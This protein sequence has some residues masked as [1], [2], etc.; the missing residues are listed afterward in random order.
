M[1]RRKVLKQLALAIPGSMILPGVLSSCVDDDDGPEFIFGGKVIVIGAG[2]A[3]LYAA[4]YLLN[5]KVNVQVLEAS[6]FAGG[7]V[8]SISGF[9]DFPLEMGASEIWGTNNLLHEELIAASIP[10]LDQKPLG[11]GRYFID[12]AISTLEEIQ[13]DGDFNT[14]VNFIQGIP[15]YSGPAGSIRTAAENAGIDPRVMNFLQGKVGQRY[16][17]NIQQLSMPAIAN[18][19]NASES[20]ED[21]RVMSG[22]S[23]RNFLLGRYSRA[24][25]N[26]KFNTAVTQIDYSDDK[27]VLTDSTGETYTADK[28]ILTVPISMIKNGAINFSPGLPNAKIQALSRMEMSACLRI[29]VRFNNNFWGHDVTRIFGQGEIARYDAA[30][31]GR[32]DINRTL[33]ATVF[34]TTAQFYGA[35]G[36]AAVNNVLNDLSE[37][38]NVNANQLLNKFDIFDWTAEPFIEGGVSYPTAAGDGMDGQRLAEPINDMLYFAGEATSIDGNFGTLHGALESGKRAAEEVLETILGPEEPE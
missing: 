36:S 29:A 23:L 17:A 15:G 6:E 34:G 24:I 16:G 38:Y 3:G 22:N 35:A 33:V 4:N 28:V 12:E 25:E 10:L 31:L 13:S 18:A 32:S 11:T 19:M 2:A 27:V 20:D 14:L 9:S 7:R 37:M 1:E 21:T 5:K 30:G 26:T 8:R